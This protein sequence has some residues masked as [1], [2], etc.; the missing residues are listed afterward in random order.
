MAATARGKL[1]RQHGRCTGGGAQALPLPPSGSSSISAASS[2]CRNTGL[3]SSSLPRP[4]N[5]VCGRQ[6]AA[7]MVGSNTARAQVAHDACHVDGCAGLPAGL[8]AAQFV[9]HNSCTKKKRRSPRP[10]RGRA[11]TA[12]AGCWHA[13]PVD[14]TPPGLLRRSS[15]SDGGP[16]RQ[17]GPQSLRPRPQRAAAPPAWQRRRWRQWQQLAGAL[18]LPCALMS[19]LRPSLN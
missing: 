10:A 5:Q 9:Q 19:T 7:R 1:R 3:G 15:Q 18:L 12:A 11:Q 2:A 13:R 16:A 8:G 4:W 17:R 14:P 6:H